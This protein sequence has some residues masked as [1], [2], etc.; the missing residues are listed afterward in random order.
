MYGFQTVSE[1][2]NQFVMSA[3]A[4]LTA[5]PSDPKTTSPFLVTRPGWTA[6]SMS[7]G[8]PNGIDPANM[9][10]PYRVTV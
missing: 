7:R 10:D 3:H 1:K 6:P 5:L 9:D 8:W 2:G 4:G